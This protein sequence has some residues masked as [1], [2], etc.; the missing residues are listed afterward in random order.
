MYLLFSV[1]VLDVYWIIFFD[2][3]IINV[4]NVYYLYMGILIVL[5]FGFYVFIWIIRLFG[6]R[7]YIIELVVNNKIVNV[8]YFS[9]NG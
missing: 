5:K 2:I 9:F 8:L 7:Y 1:F 6:Y 4:G 3:V